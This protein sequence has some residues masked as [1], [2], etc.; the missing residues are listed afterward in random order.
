MIAGLT[1]S[2]ARAV[3][4]EGPAGR[5]VKRAHDPRLAEARGVFDKQVLT[6]SSMT[7]RGV[8]CSPAVSFEIS[9]NL[10]MSSSKTRPI[11]SLSSPQGGEGG[12]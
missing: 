4:A 2:R 7:S 12:S 1:P 3:L 5:I 8:K 6:M 11:V 9:A 10:R